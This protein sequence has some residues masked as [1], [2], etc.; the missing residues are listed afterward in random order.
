M[1]AR[2]SERSERNP[3]ITCPLEFRAREAGDRI[4]RP[5]RARKLFPDPIQ[6]WRDLRSLTPG[7]FLPPLRGWLSPSPSLLNASPPG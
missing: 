2:V 1:V 5:F 7:Y 3:G 4:L 6:G